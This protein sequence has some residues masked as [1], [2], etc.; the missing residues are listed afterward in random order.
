MHSTESK[1]F[2]Q[3]AIVKIGMKKMIDQQIK[4]SNTYNIAVRF[5]FNNGDDDYDCDYLVLPPNKKCL[6]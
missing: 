2:I 6:K 1:T 5:G 3:Q 4:S